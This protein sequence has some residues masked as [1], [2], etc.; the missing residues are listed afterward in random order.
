MYNI[1]I[2][3]DTKQ[4]WK[5]AEELL[6]NIPLDEMLAKFAVEQLLLHVVT[7]SS[8][9]E[10]AESF[11]GVTA[12]MERLRLLHS[13]TVTTT[14]ETTLKVSLWF[15]ICICTKYACKYIELQRRQK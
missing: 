1:I 11:A 9:K 12:C 15:I 7:C 13:N 2:S 5:V 3:L 8:N 10:D 6:R 4:G 14:I